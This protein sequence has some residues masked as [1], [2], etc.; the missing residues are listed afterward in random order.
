MDHLHGQGFIVPQKVYVAP[1]PPNFVRKETICFYDATTGMAGIPL[2][3]AL[4]QDLG[5][6][7][8]GPTRPPTTCGG[9]KIGIRILVSIPHILEIIFIKCTF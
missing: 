9:N 3:K 5:G 1:T 8:D 6:L 7:Q 2:D 4:R